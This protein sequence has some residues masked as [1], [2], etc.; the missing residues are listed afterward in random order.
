MLITMLVVSFLGCCR[1]EV[2]CGLS[3]VV[4]GLQVIAQRAITCYNIL[5]VSS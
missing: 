5:V 1:L 3:G 2:R 4:S